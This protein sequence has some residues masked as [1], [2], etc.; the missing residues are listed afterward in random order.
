[1]MSRNATHPRWRFNNVANR[2][3]SINHT[4]L[5]LDPLSV[6]TCLC[7]SA[8][9]KKIKTQTNR[10]KIQNPDL[11]STIADMPGIGRIVLAI[12][13]DVVNQE[14]IVHLHDY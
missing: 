11:K 12:F 13:R 6:F 4:C 5:I 10:E 2:D 1:M 3:M 14:M 8:F 7:Y 9:C